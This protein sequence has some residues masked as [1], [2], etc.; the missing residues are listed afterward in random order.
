VFKQSI[1]GTATDPEALLAAFEDGYDDAGEE[2]VLRRLRE[3][4][5]RGRY[6]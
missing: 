3:I 6:Q 5:E 4:E 2:D 1:A